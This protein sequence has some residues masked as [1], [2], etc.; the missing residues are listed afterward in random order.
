VASSDAVVGSDGP[1]APSGVDLAGIAPPAPSASAPPVDPREKV[2]GV[3]TELHARSPLVREAQAAML[4]GD[5]ARALSLAQ[6]A[7]AA[8]MADADAWLTLAAARKAGGDLAGARD[9]Y[10]KCVA[11]GR[12]FT[13]MSCRALAARS[14]E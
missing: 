4:K 7:V 10:A 8:N 3:R 2:L 5:T 12:T 6:Q 9:A 11:N 13:V 1:P 14:G